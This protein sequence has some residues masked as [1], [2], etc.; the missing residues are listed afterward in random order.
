MGRATAVSLNNDR[1]ALQN[2]SLASC[3]NDETLHM[4]S[5]RRG[6]RRRTQGC[7]RKPLVRLDLRDRKLLCILGTERSSW[8]TGYC[9]LLKIWCC[10]AIKGF[11]EREKNLLG[12][13]FLK[14][15]IQMKLG[16]RTQSGN[17]MAFFFLVLVTLQA[18]DF[19]IVCI[20]Y[21]LSWGFNHFSS[22]EF[23]Q[24]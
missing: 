9:K 20:V 12:R 14:G 1:W 11:V 8:I 15:D 2:L 7:C 21:L 16:T 6:E 17:K 19:W 10:F 22:M 5:R 23:L 18:A 24:M 3:L 13:G 4:C